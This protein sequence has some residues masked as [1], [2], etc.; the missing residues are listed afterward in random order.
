MV[1]LFNVLDLFSQDKALEVYRRKKPSK[2]YIIKI[3]DKVLVKCRHYVDKPPKKQL[4]VARLA[5]IDGKK[6]YFYPINRDYA[7]TI[8]TSSTLREIGIRTNFNKILAVVYKG[9]K[10]Y[11]FI[12]FINLRYPGGADDIFFKRVHVKSLKWRVRVIDI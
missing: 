3:D 9:R 2:K 8:Y 7:E 10:W 1:L 12:T 11:D 4:V 5:A 6:F